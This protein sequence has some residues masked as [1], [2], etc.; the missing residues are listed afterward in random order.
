[1]KLGKRVGITHPATT[2][3]T[4][5]LIVRRQNLGSGVREPH[6]NLVLVEDLNLEVKLCIVSV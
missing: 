2:R 3:G 6:S 5:N 4:E 1:M